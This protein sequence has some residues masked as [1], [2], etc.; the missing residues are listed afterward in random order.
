M[1]ALKQSS[2]TGSTGMG[3]LTEKEGE[4]LQK[5]QGSLNQERQTPETLRRNITRIRNFAQAMKSGITITDENEN[6][7]L[8]R[9][10]SPAGMTTRPGSA[11]KSGWTIEE[12]K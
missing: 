11:Q 6:A 10:L 7:I 12:V 3:S 4:I 1:L 2:Q 5:L 8:N 9:G